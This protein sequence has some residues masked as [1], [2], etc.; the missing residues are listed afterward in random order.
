M[1][2]QFSK[3]QTSRM[4]LQESLTLLACQIEIPPTP[5]AETRDRHLA[6]TAEKLRA[7]LSGK[8]ADV[9]VL[10]ELSSIDYSRAAFD[11]LDEISEPLD[12]PSFQTWAPLA[13]D[14]GVHICYGFARRAGADTYIS[15]AVVA[16]DGTLAGHYDKLHLCQYGASMEKEYFSAG[17]DIFTFQIKGFTLSPIICYDIRFPELSR[18]LVLKHGVDVILHCGAYFRD[19]SFPTWHAFATTRAIENQVFFLSLNRAGP[20]YGNSLFCY[21]W[22]DETCGP[23]QFA[24]HDE[25]FRHIEID[26]ARMRDA[27]AG[28]TF[29]KDRW[30]SYDLP[31][32]THP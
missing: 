23:L 11:R 8:R 18:M 7:Q 26:Q 20:D 21:P 10:P 30:D 28:Y 31:C 13:V 27:R 15:I 5:N 19:P 2:L 3:E 24:K 17:S 32:L 16:P 22:M 4:T 1:I 25:D 9:V 14:F 12:G 6:K 29:L